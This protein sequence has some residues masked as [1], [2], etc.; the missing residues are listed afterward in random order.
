[1]LCAY[2]AN[3]NLSS[4][5]KHMRKLVNSNLRDLQTFANDTPT[6]VAFS[7]G[8]C[9]CVCVCDWIQVCVFVCDWMQVCVLVCV[10]V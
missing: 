5:L 8:V 4:Q 9:V 1:V 7:L 3:Q 6:V 10:C 2:A